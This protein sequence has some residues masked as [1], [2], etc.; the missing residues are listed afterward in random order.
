MGGGGELYVAVQCESNGAIVYGR[1]MLK[2]LVWRVRA[3]MRKMRKKQRTDFSFCYDPSS[4]ALNFDNGNFGF[5][6]T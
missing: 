3:E 5:F 1:R 4:Y 6:C 2:R